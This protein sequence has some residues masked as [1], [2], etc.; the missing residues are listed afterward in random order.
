MKL[1]TALLL[2]MM[3]TACWSS[4]SPA[5]APHPT[6]PKIVKPTPSPKTGT[7]RI[8]RDQRARHIGNAIA[9]PGTLRFHY[10]G[11]HVTLMLFTEK[12]WMWRRPDDI[13]RLESRWQGDELQYRPPFGDWTRL[14]LFRDGHYETPDDT[15]PWIYEHVADDAK[16]ADDRKLDDDRPAHDYAI[17]PMDRYQP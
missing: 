14:A 2:A 11:A 9:G 6:A 15:G 16:D 12:Q 5:P 10:D 8:P 1:C 3:A 7:F 17:K 13:Y 4:S